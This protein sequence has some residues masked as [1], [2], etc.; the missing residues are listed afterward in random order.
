MRGLVLRGCT[1]AFWYVAA[2]AWFCFVT[3]TVT[4]IC[5]RGVKSSGIGNAIQF[6]D[7]PL[8]RHFDKKYHDY[9]SWTLRGGLA[10]G[11]ILLAGCWGCCRL[12]NPC[13]RG[14]MR[15]LSRS[16]RGALVWIAALLLFLGGSLSNNRPD[17]FDTTATLLET[18]ASS[19]SDSS[20]SSDASDS[21]V[22]AD[23]S[24]T[25]ATVLAP[26]GWVDWAALVGLAV[27]G[28]LMP[29]VIFALL[30]R[31]RPAD[32]SRLRVPQPTS[33]TIRN[34]M[35]YLLGSAAVMLY[36]LRDHLKFWD[37]EKNGGYDYRPFFREGE[38]PQANLVLYSTS[39]LFAS[40]AA[41]GACFVVGLFRL[42]L[43]RDA[44]RS[45]A[46]DAPSG[47]EGRHVS[48][49]AALVWGGVLIIP[50]QVKLLPEITAERGWIMPVATLLGSAVALIPL[51][52]ISWLLLTW[53]FQRRAL[54]RLARH[55]EKVPF[56]P[57]RSE[58]ALWSFV[59]FA[60]YPLLRILR[61]AGVVVLYFV[62]TLSCGAVIAGL[63]WFAIK[64]DDVFN[65]E[66]WRGMLRS[67]LFPFLQVAFA[68]L[69]GCFAYIVL[70]RIGV[71][72]AVLLARKAQK[73][74]PA[75]VGQVPNPPE[76][77]GAARIPMRRIV[78]FAAC[79]AAAAS[80]AFASWPFWGWNGV[81]ENVFTRVCEYNNRHRFELNFLHWLFDFDRDGY[82]AVLHGADPGDFDSSAQPGH[83]DPPRDDNAVPMD[84]FTV[85]D[86]AKARALPNILFIFLEGVTPTS[87]SA[88]GKRTVKGTPNIDSV[89]RDGTIFMQARC[90]YPSTWDGWF[91]TV[92]GRFLRIQ[93]MD[94]SRPF[95]DRYSRYNNLY[96]VL[97]QP[98]ISINR[99]CHMNCP[100]YYHSLVPEDMA[101]T[102]WMPNFDSDIS[103]AD[104][105]RGIWRGD[106]RN[107]R[108]LAFLDSLKPGDR[109]FAIEHMA[110]THFP[111]REIRELEWASAD[112]YLHNGQRNRLY[113]NYFQN[114]TRMD[115]QVGELLQK[116]KQKKLYDNTIII[117][118][119]DHGC[120]WWEHEHMYYVSHL[121]DQS[122]LIP[123]IVKIPGIS[124]GRRVY[125]PV[126]QV[127]ILPTIME[128]AG[129]R[130]VQPRDDYPLPGRS[131][132]PLIRDTATAA[133]KEAY[134]ERDVPLTTHYDK[135][136]VISQFRHKLIFNRPLGT[137][138]L[139]DL[140]KDPMEM[141]NIVD[142][143]PELLKEMLG[144]LRFLMRQ[145]PAI[146]GGI[147]P[148]AAWRNR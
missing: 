145:N 28:W 70:R 10:L 112:A 9:Y 124:G 22:L 12:G 20:G 67:G 50:W 104:E 18:F 120:Q 38:I 78:R 36:A 3:M 17:G 134:R 14:W 6:N 79:A 96:K 84:S 30:S 99:W 93:E 143:K 41:L 144:K 57:R 109:F 11:A 141:V 83:L 8:L 47:E 115:R 116:L 123:A 21:S 80:L 37:P 138:K 43:K 92:T 137:Y 54:A 65:F 76:V 81:R 146:I 111:W 44:A 71:L 103:G 130:Q 114:I 35:L 5:F 66:D 90:F 45:M 98:G 52:H 105:E 32:V 63:T 26:L 127:D 129:I 49:L 73:P 118:M 34:A 58:L 89:A 4:L 140:E 122:L 39:L 132:M 60:V 113:S 15:R 106:K 19:S 31:S 125:D 27:C 100:P 128:L 64:A 108:I 23:A 95:G 46:A 85:A 97:R 110:D 51:I 135:L 56:L 16:Q 133:Q 59:L 62:T 75:D 53:D 69:C 40:L 88:Y 77:P 74:A 126:L 148:S 13:S 29:P 72:V 91:S 101:S 1:S 87:I 55:P 142:D 147:Q 139:F 117:I 86:A 121:Y 25:K 7:V 107:Q 136:G 82:A 68:L 131:L 102:A 61:V 119:S 2:L 33:F 24:N 48:V 42:T 94:M